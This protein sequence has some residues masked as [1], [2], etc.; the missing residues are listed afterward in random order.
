MA[1]MLVCAIMIDA[2]RRGVCRNSPTHPATTDDAIISNASMVWF[3][4]WENVFMSLIRAYI[5]VII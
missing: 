4:I 5:D 3:N 2:K 1:N